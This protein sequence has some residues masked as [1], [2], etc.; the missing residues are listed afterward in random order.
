FSDSA[1]RRKTLRLGKCTQKSAETIRTKVESLISAAL[2]G[3]AIDDETAKWIATRGDDLH[4]KL[5]RVGLVAPRN[6]T[7]PTVRRF[8]ETY[9][10]GRNDLKAGTRAAAGF[11]ALSLFTYF[12]DTKLLRDVTPGD[13]DDFAVWLKGQG[14]ANATIGRRLIRAKQFFRAAMR[15]RLVSCN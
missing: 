4:K 12:G 7:T 5:S 10:G 6:G 9:I 3:N 13:A 11:D 15:R 8:I 2:A 14:L 1:G